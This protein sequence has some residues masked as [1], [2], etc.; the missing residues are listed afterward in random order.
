M[1]FKFAFNPFEE[2]RH[3]GGTFLDSAQKQTLCQD[4][5]RYSNF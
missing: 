1:D 5:I 4:V 3:N 2:K